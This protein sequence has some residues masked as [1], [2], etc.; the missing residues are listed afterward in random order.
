MRS[1]TGSWAAD[2]GAA[3]SGAATAPQGASATVPPA[4]PAADPALAGPPPATAATVPA[5]L[6]A[7]AGR[8]PLDPAMPELL[9]PATIAPPADGPP[10]DADPDDPAADRTPDEVAR[11]LV[12]AGQVRRRD[13]RLVPLRRGS[14]VVAGTVLG[15]LGPADPDTAAPTDAAAATDTD[16]ATAPTTTS[17][18]AAATP[19]PDP[20]PSTTTR[21]R[22]SLRFAIRPGGPEAPRIDPRP[23]V[24]GW[25][26]LDRAAV[27]GNERRSRLLADPADDG[28]DVD[29]GRLLLLSKEQLQRRVLGDRRLAIYPG[30]RADIAAGAIDRRVLATLEYLTASGHRLTITSLRTGHSYLSASGNVSEHSSGSAVDIAQVDGIT[31]TPTTQGP[32]SIT[33]R[34]IRLLL[35]LQ[36][37]MEPHQIISLMRPSDFGGAP[38]VLALGDHDDHIHVGFRPQA[39]TGAAGPRLGR[40]VAAV[41]RP[42]QWRELVDRLGRIDNPRVRR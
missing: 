4:T 6:L 2:P 15:R 18:A 16:A 11:Y 20:D 39:G 13:L 33:A 42:A 35:R 3:D 7:P 10:T 12:R 28:A 31:I 22:A 8:G 41:L 14:R 9:A 32:G 40:Q 19:D 23:I 29:V 25:R 26:L 27:F 1:G 5:E 37:A 21:R 38:N 34:T 17:D 36:G 30:G 24:D